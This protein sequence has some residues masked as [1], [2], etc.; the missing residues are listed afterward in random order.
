[1]NSLNAALE[2]L[3]VEVETIEGTATAL[4]GNVVS[5]SI[6]EDNDTQIKTALALSVIS[7]VLWVLAI[8][9]FLVKFVVGI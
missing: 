7:F 3:G 5:G 2:E 4:N 6:E 8:V 9:A 1:M